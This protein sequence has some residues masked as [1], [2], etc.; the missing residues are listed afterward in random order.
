M[1]AR[2]YQFGLRAPTSGEPAVRALIRACHEYR[3]D[4]VA[5]E[6]GRRG[7]IR[8][9]HDT[10]AVQEAAGLVRAATRSTRRA[11][12]SALHAARRAAEADA[13]QCAATAEVIDAQA[14]LD[15]LPPDARDADRTRAK[16]AL[17]EARAEAGDRI[18]QIALLDEGL[19]RDARALTPL[20]PGAWANYQTIEAAAQQMRMTPLYDTDAVTPL[21]PRFV[22]GPRLGREAFDG[23]DARE[24]WW[25]GDGQVSMHL[26]GRTVTTPDV[27]AG[28]DAWVRLELGPVLRRNGRNSYARYGTLHLR[29]ANDGREPVWASWPVKLH[30]ALPDA[31]RW[32]WVRVS[33]RRDA[34]RER[35]TVE[36]TLDDPAPRARDLDAA[37]DGAIAVELLWTPLDDGS[38]RVATWLDSAGKRGEVI[39]PAR[40]RGA[41][42]KAADIRSLRDQHRNDLLPKLASAI[43]ADGSAHPRWLAEAAATLHLW[44]SSER[45]HA[46]AHRW[47]RERYDGARAAY[48][49][50]QAW[51]LRDVHLGEYECGARRDAIRWRGDM[52]AKLAVGW[53]RQYRAVL[54]PDRDLSRE[55]RWG[56]DSE[57]RFAA[58]PQQLRDALRAAFGADALD[59]PWRGPHG[60]IDDGDD[61]DAEAP[62]WKEFAIEQ[63]RGG[64]IAGTARSAGKGGDSEEKRGGAWQ[65]RKRASAE[66]AAQDRAAREAARKVAE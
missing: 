7:A 44:R 61:A 37:L 3:N 5:I 50:L 28:R 16:R 10:P 27:L 46:L 39:L 48:E 34:W 36:I 13:S 29:V 58:S 65:R 42:R 19:R 60:V 14:A 18:A 21:D 8:A 40:V 64:R 47:R 31:A 20:S 22:R 59:A 30:R 35:W 24:A 25:L 41:L 9:I 53:S 23:D 33:C 12:V 51:E 55:A 26:Q 43:R 49:L 63:W 54:V 17:R 2:V 56:E 57:H 62:E 66:R 52:Y 45:L 15:A 4:L 6:R 1:T 11:A 38:M 32:Q